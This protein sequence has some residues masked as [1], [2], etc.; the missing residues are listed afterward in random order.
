MRID[1][2]I[3]WSFLAVIAGVLYTAPK[4]ILYKVKEGF[5]DLTG[6]QVEEIRT[7]L[8]TPSY[9]DSKTSNGVND[10]PKN[11]NAGSTES[12]SASADT[13]NC[14]SLADGQG[15]ILNE[16]KETYQCPK[17][18]VI[19]KTQTQYVPAPAKECPDLRNFI[20]KDQIPCW[21]CK[22]SP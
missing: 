18:T 13:Q 10:I 8:G 21:N 11:I 6:K 9:T 17:P 4:S 3:K 20:R 12:I 15:A 14:M 22:L 5:H 16:K 1:V 19:Y 7:M 2:L